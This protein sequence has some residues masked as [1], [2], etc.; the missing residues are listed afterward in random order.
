MYRVSVVNI[1]DSKNEE[2]VIHD[3]SSNV[4]APKIKGT[5]KIGINVID[6]FTFTIYFDNPGYNLIKPY[7]SVIKVYN[8]KKEKYEFIG[9]PITPSK[10]MEESGV[11]YKNYVC[12]SVKGF[13]YDSMQ[14]YG[15][16]H[17]VSPYGYFDMLISNHNKTVDDYKKFRVGA[18]TVKDN[19]D[20]LYRYTAYESTY[21]NIN[22]DLT[23]PLDGE[24]IVRY[25]NGNAPWTIDLLSNYGVKSTTKIKMGINMAAITEKVDFS[26]FGTR[27]IPL[28]SKIKAADSDGNEKETEKR[29]S[30]EA[31]NDGKK[32]IDIPELIAEYGIIEKV[33]VFDNVTIADNLLKKG[34]QYAESMILSISNSI[35]AYDLSALGYDYDS[36]EVGNY[37]EIEHAGLDIDYDARLIEKTIVIH[38]PKSNA[39]TFGEHGADFKT[40]LKLTT[41]S[42]SKLVTAV[43]EDLRKLPAEVLAQAKI[44]ATELIQM[45]SAGN[46][47]LHLNKKMKPFE[48]LIMDTDDINTA[49]KIWRWNLNG[50]GYSKN[51]YKGEYG[52]AITM[53]GSIVADYITAGT[54]RGIEIYNG[55]GS[56]HV[57]KDGHATIKKGKIGAWNLSEDTNYEGSLYAENLLNDGYLYR[58]WI[59]QPQNYSNDPTW[60]YSIQK[61]NERGLNP[62]TLSPI[63]IV[64]QDGS[65]YTRGDFQAGG[66][67]AAPDAYIN[68]DVIASNIYLKRSEDEF[69]TGITASIDVSKPTTLYVYKGLITTYAQ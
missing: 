42:L 56:F 61:G 4:K 53:D 29:V 65:I 58:V 8:I 5:V 27:I 24:L 52:T 10:Q 51:G 12:E 7:C 28:G 68:G 17:N 2:V 25:G 67:F 69:V 50:L 35:S 34:K 48:I 14:E 64:R 60:I 40:Y 32:Y 37:Y 3:L 33:V 19:N 41:E 30:I 16:Y 63:F 21:K 15:E 62:K 18:V 20:S 47:V 54:L 45:C 6:S 22:D 26:N 39:L 59:N 31:V 11:F 1:N 36:F 66:S 57:T 49:K 9:R 13:L 23:N 46:V 38:D 44:N 43:E 55:D